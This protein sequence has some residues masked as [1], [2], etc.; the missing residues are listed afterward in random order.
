MTAKKTAEALERRVCERK[1]MA[2]LDAKLHRERNRAEYNAKARERMAR[3]RAEMSDSEKTDYRAKQRLYSQ[4]YYE[5]YHLPP[6]YTILHPPGLTMV[7]RNRNTILDK[8][9]AKRYGEY[10][11]CYGGDS[12][13]RNYRFRDVK[14][15]GMLNL[16]KDSEEYKSAVAS[17]RET[18]AQKLKR[19]RTGND[20]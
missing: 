12:F 16:P 4:Q 13:N 1:H 7:L 15:R 9:D 10:E 5:R 2:Q 20:I 18:K 19:L 8:A 11:S 3:K 14:P 6:H 17:W